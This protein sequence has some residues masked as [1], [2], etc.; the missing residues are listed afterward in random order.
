MGV[1]HSP[2]GL[3]FWRNVDRRYSLARIY[4]NQ[5]WVIRRCNKLADP[6]FEPRAAVNQY[7]SSGHLLD[8]TSIRCEVVDVNCHGN[9]QGDAGCISHYV[10]GEIVDRKECRQNRNARLTAGLAS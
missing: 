3:P 8:G 2:D 1:D 10:T 6:W 4:Q 7:S 9:Q 5:V